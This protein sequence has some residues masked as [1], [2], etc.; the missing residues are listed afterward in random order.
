MW[1]R[2]DIEMW[3]SILVRFS[4]FTLGIHELI[5][6]DFKHDDTHDLNF[7]SSSIFPSDW[8]YLIS[9]LPS[10]KK[11]RDETK[12]F[13]R[14]RN[15]SRFVASHLFT[16][17]WKMVRRKFYSCWRKIALNLKLKTNDGAE[18]RTWKW[19]TQNDRNEKEKN[20]VFWNSKKRCK[21]QNDA[22]D[23]LHC[24]YWCVLLLDRQ[25]LPKAIIK[26]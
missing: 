7:S 14:L 10:S 11:V 1:H 8:K 22:G 13:P 4:N 15:D 21:K 24:I 3:T 25:Q 16:E 12:I 9:P 20:N 18:N 2:N 19:M 6:R 17:L 26:K 23:H 5:E